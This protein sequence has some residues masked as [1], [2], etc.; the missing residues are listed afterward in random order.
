MTKEGLLHHLPVMVFA[1]VIL[2]Q[3][4]LCIVYNLLY[5]LHLALIPIAILVTYLI[6]VFWKNQHERVNGMVKQNE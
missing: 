5:L 6:C 1:I 4:I 2:I 3:V